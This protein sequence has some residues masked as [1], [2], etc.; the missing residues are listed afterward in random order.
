MSNVYPL[1]PK[2]TLNHRFVRDFLGSSAPCF[3]LGLIGA[4][5]QEFALL[6]LRPGVELPDRATENG[7]GFGHSVLGDSTYEIVHFAFEFSG[8]ATYNTLLNPSDPLVRTVL[9][10]MVDQGSYFVLAIDPDQ[11]ITTFRADVGE[12]ELTGLI[13][14]FP[15]IEHSA[16]NSARYDQVQTQFQRHPEPPGKMLE[17]VCR[18]DLSYL[19]LEKDLMELVPAP[20]S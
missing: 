16:T 20:M 11:H 10:R 7:F 19:D 14:H 5:G 4:L 8:F 9:R 2:L 12:A 13:N 15:R 3:A 17:W 1:L 18:G 6:A